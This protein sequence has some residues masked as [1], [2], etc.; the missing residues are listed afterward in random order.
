MNDFTSIEKL[1]AELP[2]QEQEILLAQVEE[3]RTALEREEAQ[4]GF[5][6]YVKMMW[7][8]FVHGRHHAVMAKK[9]EAIEIG[10]AHV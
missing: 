6:S 7:P 4:K 8:G 5:M 9:F 3:Y 1:M 2:I 10:R